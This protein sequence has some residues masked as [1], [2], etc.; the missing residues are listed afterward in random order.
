MLLVQVSVKASF[1]AY[2]KHVV[3]LV[4]ILI[5]QTSSTSFISE[6]LSKTIISENS[7]KAI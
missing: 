2:V 1:K 3:K 7:Y 4:L 5:F 6:L